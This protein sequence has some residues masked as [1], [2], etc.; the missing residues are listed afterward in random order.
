[1]ANYT[2]ISIVRVELNG[3]DLGSVKGESPALPGMSKE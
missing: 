1:M 2:L 3:I